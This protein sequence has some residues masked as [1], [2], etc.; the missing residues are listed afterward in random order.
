M[1]GKKNIINKIIKYYAPIVKDNEQ[2]SIIYFYNKSHDCFCVLY[3]GD[4]CPISNDTKEILIDIERNLISE[5]GDDAPLFFYEEHP[6]FKISK[7]AKK[8][9]YENIQT[10]KI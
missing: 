2:I 9:N 6:R 5:L 3:K 10:K 8:I 1:K 4:G 7:N